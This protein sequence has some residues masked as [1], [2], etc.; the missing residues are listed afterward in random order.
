[1]RNSDTFHDKERGEEEEEEEEK[2]KLGEGEKEIVATITIVVAEESVVQSRGG[3][4][5]M[6]KTWKK[7][8]C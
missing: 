1:L 8:I 5:R 6:E 4:E 3:I 7:G 2:E